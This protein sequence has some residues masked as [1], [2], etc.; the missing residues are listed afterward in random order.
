VRTALAALS[1]AA[2]GLGAAPEIALSAEPG[3]LP[4]RICA[5]PDNLPFTSSQAEP[6]GLY[7]EFANK[8]AESLG[9]PPEVVWFRNIYG[10][11]AVR[12]TLLEGK[13]DMYVGLPSEGFMQPRV[14]FSKPFMQIGYAL[15]T[16]QGMTPKGAAAA[17]LQGLRGKR[18]AAQFAS[19]PQSLLAERSDMQLVT[20]MSPE[21]A[22]QAMADGKA[23]AALLWGP[24]AGY[25]NKTVYSQ[26]YALQPVAGKGMQWGV[27]I[28]FRKKDAE[29]RAA[30][31]SK[32]D[33]LSSTALPALLTKYGFPT[34]KPVDIFAGLA[35]A[36][37][38]FGIRLAASA[39][40]A[41]YLGGADT[42]AAA[43]PAAAAPAVAAPAPA[44]KVSEA[45]KP[46]SGDDL[47]KGN[48]L[49]NNN[50]SH[51]HGPDAAGPEPKTDLRRL[52]KRYKDDYL[53][54]FD[55]T[56]KEG[57]QDKGMPI[58]VGVLPDDELK[59]IRAF[60][61]SVQAKPKT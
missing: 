4:L 17:S 26:G 32:I 27:A 50:C 28:G 60:V 22:F 39:L 2:L 15:V 21:E 29:L 49:F 54:I 20:V 14:A 41:T 10:K 12:S 48:T 58:W 31:D 44:A 42:T 23:D 9:R 16:P 18:V 47:A 35:P 37:G 45:A 6:K 30:V 24:A 19:P 1:L 11:R 5:D 25:L 33:E 59:L 56:V 51:C 46:V 57:R 40:T 61:A 36:A 38:N 13:C 53:N 3:G 7:L 34:Q 55:K 52:T 8:L 43:T